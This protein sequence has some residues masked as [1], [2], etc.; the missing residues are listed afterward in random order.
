MERHRNAAILEPAPEERLRRAVPPRFE[1]VRLSHIHTG[2]PARVEIVERSQSVRV[3]AEGELQPEGRGDVHA[4]P[5]AAD[6]DFLRQAC[7][8]QKEGA[9][10]GSFLNGY[11]LAGLGATSRRPWQGAEHPDAAR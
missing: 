10:K 9:P 3:E 1:L 6:A 7:P 11:S 4:N 8:H 5:T 2:G